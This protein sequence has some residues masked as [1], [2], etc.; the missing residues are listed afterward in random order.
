M[1]LKYFA[2]LILS[3]LWACKDETFEEPDYKKCEITVSEIVGEGNCYTDVF[4]IKT[5]SET[6]WRISPKNLEW[7]TFS[8]LRGKGSAKIEYTFDESLEEDIREG[9]FLVE[10]FVYGEP[11]FEQTVKVKQM[12]LSPYVYVGEEG[13]DAFT[14]VDAYGVKDVVMKVYSNTEWKIEAVTSEDDDTPVD[15]IDFDKT[16]GE[17]R[18]EVKVTIASYTDLNSGRE[19][20]IKVYSEEH[21]I[22]QYVNVN[23]SKL[24]VDNV[25]GVKFTV[26]GM[27]SYVSEGN[28]QIKLLCLLDNQEIVSDVTVTIENGNTIFNLQTPLQTLKYKL[29]DYTPASGETKTLGVTVDLTSGNP[30]II[31]PRWDKN[32]NRFG[33]DTEDEPLLL[34]DEN[35]LKQLATLVNSGESYD[36]I[37]IKLNNEIQL[38]GIWIPIGTEANP[39]MGHFDGGNF[40]VIGLKMTSATKC[41]GLFGVVKGESHSNMASIA[42]VVLK[43]SAI[44][45]G[46]D[47][48][49]N[50]P[51]VASVVGYVVDNV[52]IKSCVSELKLKLRKMSG[53]IVGSVGT[54]ADAQYPTLANDRLNV[55]IEDCHNK[56]DI[57]MI[58][59]TSTPPAYNLG[60]ITG[61]NM[62]YV[63]RCS[64]TG[65]IQLTTNKFIQVGGIVGINLGE[66][67]E[68]YNTGIVEGTGQ[69][70]GIVGFG[71]GTCAHSIYDCYNTGYIKSN[72]NTSGGIIGAVANNANATVTMINCYNIGNT[73]NSAG[74]VIGALNKNPKFIIRFCGAIQTKLVGND[75]ND[76]S[77]DTGMTL[78]RADRLR[79]LSKEQM[80][81]KSTFTTDKWS[82]ASPNW[83]F[84]E[85]WA[86]DEGRSTPYLKNNKQTPL[87][88]ISE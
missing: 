49:A 28:G 39:F 48:V 34:Y 50:N 25:T 80:M 46:Y 81:K 24:N 16:E 69:T 43:S 77:G 8:E 68:S 41:S 37:Y 51:F 1:K 42:N 53:G 62:G 82:S 21:G 2:V 14:D 78:D 13:L 9:E 61:I 56:G 31:T 47:I 73:D 27:D 19:A 74:G 71:V 70:G 79:T 58:G 29:I 5:T 44:E 12:P 10:A 76:L 57:D 72:A 60:G 23:Q 54:S 64:N 66:V 75:A 26:V 22:K 3:L 59:L 38:S 17:K 7:I 45:S 33:G 6:M 67:R 20:C 83:D 87:P 11:Y 84:N 15:W 86:I 63:N 55:Y 85:V 52:N 4:E 88:I 35:E 65:N 40:A 32:F 18:Q 30:E 36:G